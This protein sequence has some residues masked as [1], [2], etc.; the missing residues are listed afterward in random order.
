VCEYLLGRRLL[1]ARIR[2]HEHIGALSDVLTSLKDTLGDCATVFT[3]EDAIIPS[4]VS[5][6]V[7]T[8]CEGFRG[9]GE[10]RLDGL[11]DG[12]HGRGYYKECG[13]GYS[14]LHTP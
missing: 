5:I 13:W 4:A 14:N 1:V 11:R 9:E 2:L 7:N 8:L 3:E 12:G 6:T 10:A